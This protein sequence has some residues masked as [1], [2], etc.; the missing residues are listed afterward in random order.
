MFH[1]FTSIALK[2]WNAWSG[3]FDFLPYGD[4]FVAGFA[5][6]FLTAAACKMVADGRI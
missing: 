2:S 5:L 6:F 4:T 3:L 1:T